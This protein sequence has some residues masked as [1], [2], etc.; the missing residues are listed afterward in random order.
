MVKKDVKTRFSLKNISKL[1]PEINEEIVKHHKRKRRSSTI[2]AN[3]MYLK[4][5]I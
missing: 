1:Q 5:I 4:N 2:L 3:K